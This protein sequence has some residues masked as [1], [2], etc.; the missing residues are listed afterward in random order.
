MSVIYWIGPTSKQ[1]QKEGNVLSRLQTAC[2]F[3]DKD[4]FL[5]L[6]LVFSLT[7]ITSMPNSYEIFSFENGRTPWRTPSKRCSG[8]D[9]K[10]NTHRRRRRNSTVESRRV[11]TSL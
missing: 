9:A 5:T 3:E 6:L 11:N 1:V 7:F 2:N 8:T 10:L 4:A